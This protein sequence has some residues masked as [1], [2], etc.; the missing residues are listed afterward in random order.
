MILYN[1]AMYL[2][3]AERRRRDEETKGR[4]DKETERRRDGGKVE[5]NG[6]PPEG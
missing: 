3:K 6:S 2:R 1:S 4:R 5:Q